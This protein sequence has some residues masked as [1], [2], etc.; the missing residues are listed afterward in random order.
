MGDGAHAAVIAEIHAIKFDDP[1]ETT[2]VIEEPPKRRS[3]TLT[4]TPEART[5]I[6]CETEMPS[7]V[8]ARARRGR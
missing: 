5:S 1:P 6:V 3:Q 2:E 7:E 8:M 4:R